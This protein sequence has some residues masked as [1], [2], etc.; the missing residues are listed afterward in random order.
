MPLKHTL[1]AIL[2]TII[3]G[4]NFTFIKWGLESFDPIML[5]AMRFIFTA[6]PLI[7]FVKRPKFN[8]VFMTYA[9]GTF[10]IQYGLLFYAMQLG[11]SA[12]LSALI[13]QI[14]VFITLFL[15][16]LLLGESINRWQII[17]LIIA[18]LGLGLIGINVGGDMPLLGFI[19]IL[20]SA[21]GWSFGNIASKKLMGSSPL[22]LVA[23]GGLIVAVLMSILSWFLEPNTWTVSTFS[24]ASIKSWLSL[25]FIVYVS[26]L[27]GFVMWTFLLQNNSASKVMPFALLVPIIGMFASVVLT[28]ETMTWWKV[29]AMVLIM[30]G[31]GVSRK[32]V[33]D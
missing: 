18:V 1:L 23:W 31:L 10:A 7:F 27:M 2:V 3:W 11:A 20:M 25:S 4:V 22:S 28:G 12:G 24:E 33:T 5:T 17:G 19:C 15:A 30:L 8:L 16:Y 9:V 13:L 32:P 26:T 29:V 6:I 14:Q 21:T